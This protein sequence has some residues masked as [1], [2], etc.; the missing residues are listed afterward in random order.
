MW[1]GTGKV[2]EHCRNWSKKGWKRCTIID[3]LDG[4]HGVLSFLARCV[5]ILVYKYTT[6]LLYSQSIEIFVCLCTYKKNNNNKEIQGF[7]FFL[8]FRGTFEHRTS[9]GSQKISLSLSSRFSLVLLSFFF[10]P[11]SSCIHSFISFDVLC[12]VHLVHLQTLIPPPHNTS[13]ILIICFKLARYSSRTLLLSIR[14]PARMQ[15]SSPDVPP[16]SNRWSCWLLARW[17]FS[18]DNDTLLCIRLAS[19]LFFFPFFYFTF[20]NTQTHT[21]TISPLA[22]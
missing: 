12:V 17:P 5:Y 21:A 13:I 3:W 9:R 11:H 4:R 22:V 10:S 15:P 6:L 2:L 18:S 7:P 16:Y 19:F 1:Q 14:A 8:L 20:S